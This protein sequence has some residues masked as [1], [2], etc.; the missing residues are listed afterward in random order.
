MPKL[1]PPPSKKVV[2]PGSFIKGWL[3]QVFFT[4]GSV[5]SYMEMPHGHLLIITSFQ[6]PF[7]YEH[8]NTKFVITDPLGNKWS[9]P[10]VFNMWRK[11][12]EA[13]EIPDIDQK[14]FR[15]AIVRYGNKFQLCSSLRKPKYKE[16]IFP[17]ASRQLADKDERE[18]KDPDF[19]PDDDE[20]LD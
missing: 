1:V 7:S 15:V 17:I 16:Q 13:G 4:L 19:V 18:K 11:T 9:S 6:K 3:G 5:R 12:V 20:E 14:Q 8:T 2:P 10:E